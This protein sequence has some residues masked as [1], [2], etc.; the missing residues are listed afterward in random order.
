MV[1]ELVLVGAAAV[2]VGVCPKREDIKEMVPAWART[3]IASTAKEADP[4]KRLK[5]NDLFAFFGKKRL[6]PEEV[7]VLWSPISLF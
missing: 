7:S 2:T 1:C 6:I 3:G 5:N 4:S